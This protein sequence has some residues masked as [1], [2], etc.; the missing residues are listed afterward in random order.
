[1]NIRVDE[2]EKEPRQNCWSA[3][4]VA[5]RREYPHNPPNADRR[6]CRSINT[7]SHL[8]IVGDLVIDLNEYRS[9]EPNDSSFSRSNDQMTR[10]IDEQECRRASVVSTDLCDR[11]SADVRR[12][13]TP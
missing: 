10:C 11:A 3:M 8:V 5:E 4:R 7:S 13:G 9:T 1:M 6:V 12:A 2:P